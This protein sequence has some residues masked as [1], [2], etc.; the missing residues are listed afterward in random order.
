MLLTLLAGPF[1]SGGQ[2]FANGS[3]G[4]FA[5]LALYA[6]FAVGGVLVGYWIAVALGRDYRSRALRAYTETRQARPRR[7]V[8]R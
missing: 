4:F 3:D 5:Q 7:I 8:R 1:V 6:G 2:P